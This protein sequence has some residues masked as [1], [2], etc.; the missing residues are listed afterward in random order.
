MYIINIFMKKS[1][2]KVI[3]EKQSFGKVK[4]YYKDSKL[5]KKI[6]YTHSNPWQY[7]YDENGI[8][9]LQV[10]PKKSHKKLWLGIIGSLVILSALYATYKSVHHSSK[11]ITTTS[12]HIR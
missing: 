2:I 8:S 7:T 6:D 4:S 11:Q 3:T 10:L 1:N 12:Q 5:I 9:H